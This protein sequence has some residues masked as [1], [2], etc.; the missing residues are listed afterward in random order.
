MAKNTKTNAM[1]F[2]DRAGIEYKMY[3]YES[4]DGKNDGASVAEKIGK[5]EAEVFKTL[6]TQGVSREFFVFIIPVSSELNLKKAAAAAGEKKIEMIPH[7]ELLSVT[8]Y[9]KGGCS[10]LGM[11]KQYRT[12]L[13]SSSENI[14]NIVVSAG[15]IGFQIEL[16]PEV[17][18][19]LT[20]G[21]IS[22]LCF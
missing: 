16:E 13:D 17:L 5:P 12:F 18:L 19:R 1:R 21:Q 20:G 10:P 22:E 7:R 9:I 11:K 8:G 15:K 6:V 2:L 14:K 3:S 4:S